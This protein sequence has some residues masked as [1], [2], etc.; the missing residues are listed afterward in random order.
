MK[1]VYND[2][3]RSKYFKGE[4]VG[5]C[6]T[7]AIAIATGRD[8]KEVYDTLNQMAKKESVKRHRGH[9]RSES[10]NG[11]FK[12]TWKR[13]LKNIGW[14]HV[15][16]C[17]I[18]SREDKVKFVDGAL[19]SEGTY[20]VQ[21]SRHLTCLVDGVIN[22][23]YDCSKKQYYDWE[24]GD[25]MT[26]DERCVYGYWRA[27][28]QEEKYMH[29][30]ATSLQEE[31]KEFCENQKKDLAKK[32]AEVKKHNDKVKKS[33]ASKINKLKA[34]LRKLE[35]ERDSKLLPT[36]QL[37]KDAWAK[38]CISKEWDENGEYDREGL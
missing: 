18:G 3:G 9:K 36:P 29:D 22:D 4:N 24:T 1:F 10:R 27:P 12:E 20:I 37:E 17:A 19:P 31:Y 8:Y 7:R 25:L 14:V 16:T 21:L 5:D 11:V 33:Y 35:K 34:Q 38:H 15:S 23:T 32:R 26:N 28:T 2:G 13:Y 30:D 6:V